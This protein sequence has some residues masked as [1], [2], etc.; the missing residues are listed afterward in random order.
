MHVEGNRDVC[1]GAGMCVLTAPDVFAQDDDGI[2]TV[3]REQPGVAEEPAVRQA[4]TL[5]PTG[6]VRVSS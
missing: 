5:C 4:A 2:V 3:L 1:V 6:A